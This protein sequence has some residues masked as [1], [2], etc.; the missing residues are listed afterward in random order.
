MAGTVIHVTERIDFWDGLRLGC[1]RERMPQDIDVALFCEIVLSLKGKFCGFYTC[2][3]VL[4][5]TTI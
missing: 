5:F 4:I 2:Q 1:P 3:P